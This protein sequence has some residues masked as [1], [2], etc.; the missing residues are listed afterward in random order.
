MVRSLDTQ[1]GLLN[2]AQNL[3]SAILG[4][5][6]LQVAWSPLFAIV[7]A[8]FCHTFANFVPIFPQSRILK[9]S[10]NPCS[11]TV[12]DSCSCSDGSS[13]QFSLEATSNP[14]SGGGQPDTCYC[15]NG[16]ILSE[17]R[18]YGFHT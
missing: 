1:G 14:C 2:V 11:G 10:L 5:P 9:N 16:E 6:A 13:F 4:S 12:P 7:F 17:S 18:F 3:R 8:T 15:P